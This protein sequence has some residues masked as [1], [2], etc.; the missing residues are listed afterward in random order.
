MLI[1]LLAVQSRAATILFNTAG[2]SSGYNTAN[3]SAF[4][5]F[6]DAAFSGTKVAVAN[7]E[8]LAQVLAADFIFVNI[9]SNASPLN[10]TEKANLLAYAATGKPM[11]MLGDNHNNFGAWNEAILSP[12][13]G[14]DLDYFGN[15][16]GTS[17]RLVVNTLTANLATLPGLVNP[18]VIETG[19]KGLWRSA[20]AGT[21]FPIAALF[22]P[23]DNVVIMLDINTLN[24]ATTAQ[25]FGGNLGAWANQTLES[26]PVPAPTV[27]GGIGLC[28]LLA[29]RRR[30]AA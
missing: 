25:N 8:N 27:A 29:F 23:S 17:V 16:N 26:I 22:G 13:G 21:A 11:A 10:A 6:F 19:G 9:R 1:A 28:S 2:V 30:L 15:I 24:H 5:S 18:G 7:Y 3:S 4:T 20:M 12:F 14:D